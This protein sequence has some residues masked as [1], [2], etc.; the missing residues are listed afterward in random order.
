MTRKTQYYIVSTIG[1]PVSQPRLLPTDPVY[2]QLV[3]LS[4]HLYVMHSNA[5]TTDMTFLATVLH[6]YARNKRR[7][8]QHTV[9]LEIRLRC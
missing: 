2:S 1:A 6:E 7:K 4:K 5:V 8:T 9:A 3:S